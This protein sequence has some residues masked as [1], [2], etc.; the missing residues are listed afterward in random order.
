MIMLKQTWLLGKIN[1]QFYSYVLDINTYSCE[2][3]C[4]MWTSNNKFMLKF[5]KENNFG[6]R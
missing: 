4:K 3:L 1:F 2:Q 5:N 6:E